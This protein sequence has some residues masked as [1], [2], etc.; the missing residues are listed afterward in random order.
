MKYKWFYSV[1]AFIF[2]ISCQHNPEKPYLTP[3]TIHLLGNFNN[4]DIE[5]F[6]GTMMEYKGGHLWEKEVKFDSA[7]HIEFKF[8]INGSWEP[9]SFGGPPGSSQYGAAGVCTL[10][11]NSSNLTWDIPVAGTYKFLFNDSTYYYEIRSAFFMID[12]NMADWDSTSK[13]CENTKNPWAQF[14]LKSGWITWD[15]ANLYLGA[16]GSCPSESDPNAFRIFIDVD[17][18]AK[19]GERDFT[20]TNYGLYGT[21][22]E[23][24]DTLFGADFEV[25]Y[26]SW[27]ES[28]FV[29]LDA[30][31][32]VAT[33]MDKDVEIAYAE[34]GELTGLEVKIPWQKFFGTVPDSVKIGILW[35]LTN[36]KTDDYYSSD[37][38][39]PER[40]AGNYDETTGHLVQDR[41]YTTVIKIKQK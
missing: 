26:A 36:A 41:V 21:D 35:V 32:D 31:N 14:D 12:G 1:A 20:N 37:D 25:F 6:E 33:E 39:L 3:Y 24:T 2:F 19:T 13:V 8:V 5:D 34:G 11:S 4:W 22:L 16:V 28:H 10:A 15:S 38:Q 23:V 9:Y 29:S 30:A 17:Y 7:M 40:Q 27:G 18:G